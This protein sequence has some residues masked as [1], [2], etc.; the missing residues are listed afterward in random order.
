M[1]KTPLSDSNK[2]EIRKMME[3]AVDERLAS[4]ERD[5]GLIKADIEEIK[6]RLQNRLTF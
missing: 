6:K 1:N 4:V 2:Q 3:K 5:V